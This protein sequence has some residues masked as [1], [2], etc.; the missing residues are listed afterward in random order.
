MKNNIIPPG[1]SP[2][3]VE[4]SIMLT[5]VTVHALDQKTYSVKHIIA[6]GFLTDLL[7]L[8]HSD[9]ELC[10]LLARWLTDGSTAILRDK[11]LPY[12][13]YRNDYISHFN[14]M[15]LLDDIGIQYRDIKA[16]AARKEGKIES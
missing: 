15:V 14:A 10:K 16:K 13:E 6:K 2:L 3:Y 5:L 4:M 11:I 12:V 1:F 8:M 9:E 7:N